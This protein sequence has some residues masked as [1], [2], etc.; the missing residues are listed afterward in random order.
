MR[1]KIYLYSNKYMEVNGEYSTNINE[2]ID[3]EI[4]IYA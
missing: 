2:D 3:I 4:S 1:I